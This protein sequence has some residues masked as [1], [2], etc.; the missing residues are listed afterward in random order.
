MSEEPEKDSS[1]SAIILAAVVVLVAA[2]AILFG[3]Q[4][5]VWAEA[6]HW[7]TNSPWLLDVPQPLPTPSAPPAASPKAMYVRSYGFQF[8]APWP[9]NVKPEPSVTNTAFRFDSGQVIVFFDPQTQADTLHQ[10]QTANQGQYLTF[11]TLFGGKAFDSN[12]ALYKAVYEASPAQTSP[13]ADR[14]DSLRI[15][16]LLIWKLSFGVDAPGGISSFS[17]GTNRGFQFGDP[18]KGLP[19]A[20]RIF[21]ERDEQFRIIFTAAAGSNARVTQDDV[22]VVL[23]SLQHIPI[24]IH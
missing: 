16:Q 1:S 8:L 23:Q 9:G 12:F 10:L 7:V 24:V 18:A 19:V 2:Y 21:N 22:N 5:L 15:N 6:K 3:L 20:A 17:F 13:F 14:A 11:S 4:T